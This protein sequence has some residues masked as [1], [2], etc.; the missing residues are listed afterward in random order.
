[1]VW[2]HSYVHFCSKPEPAS[3]TP[4][5]PP[6]PQTPLPPNPL[7]PLFRL[8]FHPLRC[9]LLLL[10]LYLPPPVPVRLANLPLS[11]LSSSLYLL[12]FS[13]PPS[14]VPFAPDPLPHSSHPFPW[15]PPFVLSPPF[16]FLFLS[17]RLVTF[18]LVL[19]LPPS[20][21]AVGLIDL[22]R[23]WLQPVR[24]DESRP[25]LLYAACCTATDPPAAHFL[26]PR[27]RHAVL[28]ASF[29][30]YSPPASPTRSRSTQPTTTGDFLDINAA[31]S[32]RLEN[33]LRSIQVQT[34]TR[35]QIQYDLLGRRLPFHLCSSPSSVFSASSH[36]NTSKPIALHCLFI[37]PRPFSALDPVRPPCPVSAF[38]ALF[39]PFFSL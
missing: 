8:P 9:L 4:R 31:L 3:L 14:S 13:P 39:F 21:C 2:I 22:I 38:F 32:A 10:L 18:G 33:P 16:L 6:F 12:P 30:H 1:M 28:T 26:V 36:C 5:P 27:P 35:I 34:Q 20:L 11:G 29:R 23:S 24:S 17:I 37:C 15:P 25:L 7:P 19:L